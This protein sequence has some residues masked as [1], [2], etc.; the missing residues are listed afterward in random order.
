MSE[1][2]AA[3]SGA[4]RIKEVFPYLR[5]HD[6]AAAIDFYIQVFGAR[7]RFRL[8]EPGGRIGHAE[9]DIGPS[10]LMLS[11]EYPEFSCLAPPSVGGV[12][13]SIHLHVDDAD[14]LAARAVAAGAVMLRPPTDEFYGERSCKIRDPFGHEWM[15]GHEIERVTPEEMQR[16]YDAMFA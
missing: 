16:R 3:P 7:E 14:A 4:P 13:S 11:D 6:A 1:S 10:V 8:V 2:Q 12:A 5:V 15:I 9:L